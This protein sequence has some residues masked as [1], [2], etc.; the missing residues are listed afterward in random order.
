MAETINTG[1]ILIKDRTFLPDALRFET[2]PCATGWRLVKNLDGYRLDRKIHEAGWTF[3]WLAGELGATVFGFDRQKAVR[4]AVKRILANLKS[5][6]FNSLE[7][8]RIVSKRFLGLPYASV[9]AH[10]RH[11]QGNAFLLRAKDH[12]EWERAKLKAA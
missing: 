10:S 5:G 11:I 6:E 3:F 2:E 9:S 8:T 7:I 4:R 12:Q 1:T